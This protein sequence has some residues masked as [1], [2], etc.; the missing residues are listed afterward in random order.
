ML[1]NL[2]IRQKD[3][4]SRLRISHLGFLEILSSIGANPEFAEYVRAFG[5]KVRQCDDDF[6]GYHRET[7]EE[8]HR[9]R[10]GN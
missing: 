5:L 3:S 8:K 6:G 1:T 10:H 4:W 2:S 7:Q 9:S